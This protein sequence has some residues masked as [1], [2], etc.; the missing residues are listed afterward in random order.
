MKIIK[1]I[2]LIALIGLCIGLVLSFF[3]GC[4]AACSCAGDWINAFFGCG[5]AT[6]DSGCQKFTS[7]PTVRNCIL[8]ST[9]IGALIGGAYGV[10]KTLEDRTAAQK[11]AEL[12][13]NELDKKQRIKWADDV[14]QNALNVDRIC[15][16]NRMSDRFLVSTKYEADEQMA[17]I[18]S[19]LTKVGE[20]LEKINILAEEII[21]KG[22]APV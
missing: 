17:E 18:I 22:S 21:E 7:N 15:A 1:Y 6:C 8:Y 5:D 20:K 13:Q 4:E 3:A 2:A 19:E 11:A 14:K 12:E 10:T 16:R 9:L